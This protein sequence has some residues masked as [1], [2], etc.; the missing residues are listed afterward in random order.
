LLA[1][2]ETTLSVAGGLRT[3]RVLGGAAVGC[4]RRLISRKQANQGHQQGRTQAHPHDL[5]SSLA[6]GPS[7]VEWSNE[8]VRDEA[9]Q[10]TLLTKDKQKFLL[11]LPPLIFLARLCPLP[12]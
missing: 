5:A 9:K 1:G 4:R 2:R 8:L 7:I 12:T 6:H 10:E 3:T 11:Y